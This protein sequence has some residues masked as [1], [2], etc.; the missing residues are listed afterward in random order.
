M[1]KLRELLLNVAI[2]PRDSEN[3]GELSFEKEQI[4]GENNKVEEEEED[5]VDRSMDLHTKMTWQWSQMVTELEHDYAKAG[6]ALSVNPTVWE[7]SNKANDR[8]DGEVRKALER[9]VR[10]L[11]VSPNPNSKVHGTYARGRGC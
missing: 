3:D 10:E 6:F 8:I 7:Y 1:E 4:F 5:V 9:V 2:F 11:H